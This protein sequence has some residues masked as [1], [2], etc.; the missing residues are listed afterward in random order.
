MYYNV[1]NICNKNQEIFE[2]SL[3]RNYFHGQR[4]TPIIIKND[5]WVKRRLPGQ[6]LYRIHQNKTK[7]ENHIGTIK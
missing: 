5:L 7:F 2:G 4:P 3:T 1:V 6:R